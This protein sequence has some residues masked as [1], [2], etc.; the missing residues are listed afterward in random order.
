MGAQWE[1]RHRGTEVRLFWYSDNAFVDVV[2]VWPESWVL[3][4]EDSGSRP[5]GAH[6]FLLGS[7]SSYLQS[8]VLKCR[9]YSHSY[10]YI[11]KSVPAIV[12]SRLVCRYLVPSQSPEERSQDAATHARSSSRRVLMLPIFKSCSIFLPSVLLGSVI[13]SQVYLLILFKSP[14]Q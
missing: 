12:M 6:C 8:E 9:L 5:G 10:Y 4:G 1:G 7:F 11:Q 13:W 14:S 3:S 2:C